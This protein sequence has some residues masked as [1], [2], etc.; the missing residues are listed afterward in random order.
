MKRDPTREG[1]AELTDLGQ[2]QVSGQAQTTGRGDVAPESSRPAAALGHTTADG[3]T[4]WSA[5]QRIDE[6]FEIRAVAGMGGMGVVY[7]AYDSEL[8]G[9]VALKVLRPGAEQERFQ[10]EAALLAQLEHESIVRFV[11]HGS[12]GEQLYFVMEWLEGRD[13][14]SHLASTRL[15]VHESVLIA[16]QVASALA[17][18]HDLGVV[19]RDINP[20][21]IFLVDDD[22]ERVKVLDF[23]VAR[24]PAATRQLT[25]VGS[26]IGTPGYMAPEQAQGVAAITPAADVFGLGCVLYECVTGRRA[27][28]GQTL[29]ELFARILVDDIPPVSTL[30]SSAPPGLD[31]LVNHMLHKAAA[32]RPGHAR[33]VVEALDGLG[34]LSDAPL[35]EALPPQSESAITDAEQRLSSIILLTPITDD[36]F[37]CVVRAAL[38]H[39]IK[40]LRLADGSALAVVGNRGSATDQVAAAA[41]AALD[42]RASVVGA[43]IAVATGRAVTN[44]DKP[45][46]EAIERASAALLEVTQ[47]LEFDS[48][49]EASRVFVDQV[50]A[51]LLDLRFEVVA[52]PG[53]LRLE[54]TRDVGEPVRTVLGRRTRCVGR[55]RELSLL[56][57]TLEECSEDSVARAVLV[58]GPSGIGK[59][60][61]AHEFLRTV[62]REQ[63]DT[64]VLFA[65]GEP[66]SVGSPF[67]LLRR[68]IRSYAGIAEGSPSNA[69]QQAIHA[70]VAQTVNVQEVDR[71][72]QFLCELAGVPLPDEASGELRVT[73]FDHVLTG[74]KMLRAFEDWLHAECRAHPVLLILDDLH[75]GDLPSVRFIDAALRNLS[76]QPLMVL[77]L[78]QPE[79]V[80]TFPELWSRRGLSQLRLTGLSRRSSERLVREVLGESAT[81]DVVQRLVERAQGNPFWLEELVRAE[82]E[83]EQGSQAVVLVAQARLERLSS[84]ARLALRAASVL[85]R[86]FWDGGVLALLGPKLSSVALGQL[87]VN[88]EEREIVTERESSK[89]AGQREFEFCSS[90]LRDAAY[91]TLTAGDRER[92]HLAAGSWLEAI[93]EQDA[94]VLAEHFSQGGTEDRAVH[95][96]REGAL[97]ALRGNDWVAARERA[98]QGHAAASDDEMRARF[99]LIEAEACKWAGD[100]QRA[101][102]RSLAVL[103]SVSAGSS[104]WCKA[105]GEAVATAG[106]IGHADVYRRWAPELLKV[107]IDEHNEAEL[108]TAL[109]RGA[110]QLVLCA[111]LGLA[112]AL[113]DRGE[114]LAALVQPPAG[115]RGWML[116]ALA[117]YAGAMDNATERVELAATAALLFE[118]AG[119]LRNACLQRISVGYACVEIGAYARARAALTEG[120]EVAQRMGL[121]N[122]IPIAQAQ[123]GRA[124]ESFGKYSEAEALLHEAIEA[125]DHHGNNRL[126]GVVRCYLAQIY[127]NQNKLDEAESTAN[128]A[129]AILDAVLPMRPSALATLA[130]VRLAR[131]EPDQAL[132]LAERANEGVGEGT[133]L[134]F[135]EALVRLSYVLALR[136]SGQNETARARVIDAARRL[137]ERASL[138]SDPELKELFLTAVSENA[139]TLELA[140]SL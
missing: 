85:G 57:A 105:C 60:R 99:A 96:Y 18:A 126:A 54:G 71:V 113:L 123:L 48:D 39:G 79:V 14:A 58:T 109:S 114:R 91:G 111:E 133:R 102:D 5:G 20:R 16:R 49:V 69:Q 8:G 104:L 11:A 90:L 92:G 81:S 139:R 67:A 22:P 110:T 52:T 59:T 27:F 53:G 116:E 72:H 51:G 134:N 23:G 89:F 43:T 1:N 21:N 35:S 45:A 98:E 137:R 86:R 64:V 87:L 31:A 80:Q 140:S 26:P 65:R 15:S 17:V 115:T 44:G 61:L 13:L 118:Q 82:S 33:L 3:G 120:L 2:T 122:S 68:A 73:R 101:L 127:L 125:L 30:V 107:D 75:W 103:G 138:I 78:G 121:S 100:N 117:V 129:V 24:A 40:P 41:R 36:E 47:S 136:A 34:Q 29:M 74:D 50:T 135:G 42:I 131:R 38:A 62:G 84:E 83:A 106:K 12:A 93:G 56:D 95:W 119:D 46:G 55:R 88:L 66:I 132:S 108:I 32:G 28:S 76:E 37:E 6:R 19:H 97:Q 124:L 4:Q 94:V 25:G 70:R 10:R 130:M 128:E 7:R 77:A 9:D 63:P 112:K